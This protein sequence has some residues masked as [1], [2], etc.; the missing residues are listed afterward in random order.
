MFHFDF[1]NGSWKSVEDLKMF[2]FK[3]QMENLKNLVVE[4]L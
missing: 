4:V 3:R 1:N 2:G